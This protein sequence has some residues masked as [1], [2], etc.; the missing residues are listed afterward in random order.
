[1]RSASP[2]VNASKSL[3]NRYANVIFTL[4]AHHRPTIRSDQACVTKG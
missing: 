1:M 2:G 4:A 3:R